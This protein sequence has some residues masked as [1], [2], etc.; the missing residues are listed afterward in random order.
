MK[1]FKVSLVVDRGGNPER[2]ETIVKVIAAADKHAAVDAARTLVRH[3][4]PEKAQRI[5]AWSVER[6]Y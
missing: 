6:A 5:W 4:E 1:N 2:D 3:E